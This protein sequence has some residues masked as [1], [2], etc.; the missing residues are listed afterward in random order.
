MNA[1]KLFITV[2]AITFA[3]TSFAADTTAAA[4]AVTA[5]A[6]AAQVSIAAKNLNVPAVL[7]D[8]SAGRSRAEVKAEAIEAVKN[9]RSTTTRQFDWISK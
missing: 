1:S 4:T 9:Y 8:K 5:A 7:V 3:S 2:A 6:A